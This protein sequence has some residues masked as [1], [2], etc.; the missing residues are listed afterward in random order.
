HADLVHAPAQVTRMSQHMLMHPGRTGPA[1]RARPRARVISDHPHGEPPVWLG[2]CLD[3][4]QALHAEQDRGHI[5][6]HSAR[7]SLTIMIPL[8]RSMILE[9]AGLL[10][11]TPRPATAPSRPRKPGTLSRTSLTTHSSHIA[12]RSR[13][14]SKSPFCLLRLAA[15]GR[16]EAGEIA[17]RAAG[18]TAPEG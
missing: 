4:P 3:N 13:L 11:T 16:G 18:K 12:A 8:A 7:G 9:A 17:S 14:T 15:D 2:I 6:D 5:L 10:I 1:V